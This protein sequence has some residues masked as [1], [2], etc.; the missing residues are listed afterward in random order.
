[1][2]VKM[3]KIIQSVKLKKADFEKELNMQ[4]KNINIYEKTT[5]NSISTGQTN[6]SFV[7]RRFKRFVHSEVKYF[8]TTSLIISASQEICLVGL[9]L[10]GLYISTKKI[11]NPNYDLG[12]MDNRGKLKIRVSV[13]EYNQAEGKFGD[14][15]FSEDSVLYGIIQKGDPVYFLNFTRGIR[16][17]P[18]LQYAITVENISDIPYIDIWCG[19]VYKEAIDK[20]AQDITCHSSNVSFRFSDAK[21]LQTDF[22]EFSLGLIEGVMFAKLN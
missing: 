5:T 14:K 8:K 20:L 1:V 18:E 22:N 4:I 2:N 12:I 9:A 3:I 21:G 10:C 19:S 7:L 17:K 13:H 16:L 15:K 6:N 11:T